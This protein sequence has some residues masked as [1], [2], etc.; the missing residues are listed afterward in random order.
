MA[1]KKPKI[2]F[3][4]NA[5][6]TGLA[7]VGA[8]NPSVKIKHNKREFATIHAPTWTSSDGLWYITAHRYYNEGEENP[9]P[10]CPWKRVK[11][12]AKHETEEAAREWALAHLPTWIENNQVFYFDN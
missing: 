9:S 6:E 7:A 2:T 4:R 11:F 3:K 10:N 1:D 12:K 5:R 8:P